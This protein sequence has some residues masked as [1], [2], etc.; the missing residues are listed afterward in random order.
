[1]RYRNG[2]FTRH[3]AGALCPA[4]NRSM[5]NKSIGGKL[6]ACGVSLAAFS[7]GFVGGAELLS[8]AAKAMGTHIGAEVMTKFG[9]KLIERWRE[10]TRIGEETSFEGKVIQAIEK[11]LDE[12]MARKVGGADGVK[13][14]KTYKAEI[15]SRLFD[16]TLEAPFQGI[17]DSS[18]PESFKAFTPDI[19]K[20]FLQPDYDDPAGYKKLNGFQSLALHEAA[21][22]L[23]NKLPGYLADAYGE[24]FTHDSKLRAD[25]QAEV[26]KEIHSAISGIAEKSDAQIVLLT[27][28]EKYFEVNAVKL[29]GIQAA[30]AKVDNVTA[31][32]L[33]H[34]K[35]SRAHAPTLAPIILSNQ[36][37]PIKTNSYLILLRDNT[38]CIKLRG[39]KGATPVVPLP[40]HTAYVPLRAK[41]KPAFSVLSHGGR[42]EEKAEADIDVPLNRVFDEVLGLGNRL[43]IIGGAGSG[44]TTVLL[45]MAWVL[46]TAL[47]DEAKSDLAAEK[48]GLKKSVD[49]LPLPVFVSLAAIA[50]I[51]RERLDRNEAKPND[52]KDLISQ[53][54]IDQLYDVPTGFF[55]SLLKEKRE[56]ILLLDGLD[57]IANKKERAIFR[58]K[59]DKLALANSNLWIVATCRTVAYN[60]KTPLEADFTEVAVQRLDMEDHV[61]PMVNTAYACIAGDPLELKRRAAVLTKGIEA[62]EL[63]RRTRLGDNYAPLVDSPLMVRMLLIVQSWAPDKQLP[64]GRAE[65]FDKAVE[66]LLTAN[67]SLDTEVADELSTDWKLHRDML[68]KLAFDMRQQRP[69]Q[70]KNENDEGVVAIDE[71]GVRKALKSARFSPHIETFL[72][73]AGDRASVMEEVGGE[74]RFIHAAFQEFLAARYLCK[75]IGKEA[76]TPILHLI[77]PWLDDPWW[78]EPILLMCGYMTLTAPASSREHVVKFLDNLAKA[79]KTPDAKFSAAELAGTAALEWRHSS[80]ELKMACANRI[81][82]L[83]SNGDELKASKQPV[84]RARA[85]DALSHL[86]DSRFDPACFYLPAADPLF[87]FQ[88]IIADDKFMIGTR[89]E[90]QASVAAMIGWETK[91][92]DNEI[93]NIDTPTSEFYIA[94]YPVT[95]AQ[96]RASGIEPGDMDVLNDPDS[97]PVRYVTWKE[98]LRYCDWL[99]KQ[100]TTVPALKN[101]EIGK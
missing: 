71:R 75:V 40:L 79:G 65:L 26:L 15:P 70:S 90:N 27:K 86:G 64:S 98:A 85:G 16:A 39:I 69:A 48:L 96:F 45:H 17:W 52:I 60:G 29:D 34:V 77:E 93:N 24:T 53:Y 67:Y 54:L 100:F 58:A 95:V 62:L 32:I 101:S 31:E 38:W 5:E 44:K 43:A 94:R 12:V 76:R 22:A 33:D 99:H 50:K 28:F 18:N 14:L 20:R 49:Q 41:R 6:I 80:G 2:Q 47:S 56:I 21:D 13:L 7:A 51:R 66:A 46:A 8:S 87:G 68:Q 61:I 55:A 23:C 59:I 63:E 83:L 36:E 73:T 74:F 84:I 82:D 3:V 30:L 89:P 81:K 11:V 35:A 42:A 9:G 10:K 72:G 4:Y 78:R 19:W 91:E 97:R 57:E 88:K 1:M 25:V 92:I 37:L